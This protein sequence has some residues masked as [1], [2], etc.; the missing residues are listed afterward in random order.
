MS[1]LDFKPVV[2]LGDYVARPIDWVQYRFFS[3]KYGALVFPSDPAGYVPAEPYES[4]YSL[5]LGIYCGE[6]LAGWQYS[7]AQEGGILMR[8]TGL[9]PEHQGRGVYSAFLPHLLT[10]FAKSGFAL[11]VS[12]HRFQNNAAIIPKLKAGF[13]IVGTEIEAGVSYVKL[14]RS[15]GS[16]K[17]PSGNN[18]RM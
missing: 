4:V 13:V 16:A 1:F 14:A 3:D 17:L 8:D 11:V 18:G 5:C 15:S 7:H 6:Q 9:L 2:I 10:H 12:R